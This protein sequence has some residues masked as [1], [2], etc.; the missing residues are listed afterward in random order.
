VYRARGAGP[1]VIAPPRPAGVIEA[2]PRRYPGPLSWM[3][4]APSIWSSPIVS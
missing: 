2:R 3:M 4:I 1:G